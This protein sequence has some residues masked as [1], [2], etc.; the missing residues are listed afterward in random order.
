VIEDFSRIRDDV[1]IHADVAIVGA[2]PAGI[3]TALELARKGLSVVLLESGGL[4]YDEDA[5]QLVD[6]ASWDHKLHAPLE[7]SV[8]RQLGG[9][10][11]IWGGRCV[12][13]DPVDFD[14]RSFVDATPWPTSYAT[15]ERYFQR[16]SDWC[17]SGRA[18]FSSLRMPHLP[19]QMVPG[20]VD[21]DITS[22]ALERWSLP[23]N[24]GTAHGAALR[25]TRDLRL[26]TGVTCIGIQCEQGESAA[27]SL[28]CRT[29]VGGV[30]TVIAAEFVVAGGGLES[31]RLLMAS[32]SPHGG[33]LG[34]ESDHLGR[35]Y[36]AHLEGV[37][38]EIQFATPPRETIYGYERDIDGVYVRRR[39]SFTRE[40]QL[41][42]DLPNIAGWITNPELADASHG[43]GQLSFVYL[44][45][46][47]PFGPKFAPDAQRLSLT[48]VE[49]P[50]TPYGRTTISPKR[51]HL[52]NVLSHPLDTGRFVLDFGSRRV[53]ARGRKAPGFFVYNADNRYRFQYHAEH[54]PHRDSRVT[55]SD[56]SDR[57]GMPKLDIDLRF[58]SADIDGVV[59]AHEHWDYYL[60]DLGVG[61]LDYV[62]DDPHA[63]VQ[64]R[65]GGGFH[66]VGTTRMSAVSKDGVVNG[67]LKVHSVDNVYVASSSTFV[68]SGQANSTFMIVAF[69]VRLADRLAA[70]HHR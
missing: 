42:H 63:T 48:G 69:A 45:L 56:E 43:S 70:L 32:T 9:T 3:V 41:D 23:T 35:W 27:R 28:T 21:G 55:L 52:H 36:M 15:M 39:L 58:S 8:R 2:G 20:L 26:L 34:N 14:D 37:A 19:R 7:I 47:S 11:V 46:T 16:A 53:L 49:I 22:T 40:F 65:L 66:Q 68:T 30:V 12:P 1:T 51:D 50:G 38:A 5:Q 62:G 10:S 57:L 60:R 24:F 29:L 31:T 17:L 67:D 54:L 44:A 13:Y 33:Q 18:V 4:E 61:W 6:A 25:E 59:R 64:G